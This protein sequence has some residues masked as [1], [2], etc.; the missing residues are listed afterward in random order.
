MRGW[1]KRFKAIK[2]NTDCCIFL[3]RSVFVLLLHQVIIGR[4]QLVVQ[5]KGWQQQHTRGTC[6]FC[7]GEQRLLSWSCVHPPHYMCT[8]FNIQYSIFN[9]EIF[10]F[11][12]SILNIQYWNIHF[13][14]FNTQYSILK[15]SQFNIQYYLNSMMNIE[16]FTI[17]IQY[18]IHDIQYSIFD[19]KY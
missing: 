9:I 19:I 15:H 14:I 17:N 13:S 8:I 2:V 4:P 3:H 18:S 10:T 6:W 12:Y 5:R 1:V 11:Q 7:P 16:I